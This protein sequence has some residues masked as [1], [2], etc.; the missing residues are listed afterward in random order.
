M[1]HVCKKHQ[2]PA[3]YCVKCLGDDMDWARNLERNCR[4][5]EFD[6]TI[7]EYAAKIRRLQKLVA[8]KDKKLKELYSTYV[9]A[10]NRG[11]PDPTV[12]LYGKP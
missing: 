11:L 5:K 8:E 3:M 12:D 2:L 10:E 7:R 6:A 9:E 4:K 1:K